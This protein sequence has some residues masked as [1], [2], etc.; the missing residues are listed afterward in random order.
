VNPNHATINVDADRADP[1]GV[2]AHYQTLVRLRRSLPVI[3]EGRFIPFAAEDPRVFAYLR[4]LDGTRLSVVANFTGET[5]DFDVPEGLAG[6][7]AGLVWN[8]APRDEIA[9]RIRLAPYEA[10]AI[11]HDAG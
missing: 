1:K 7:G 9:G 3:A 4:E 11:L 2:F 6:R 10:V 8:V 5:A